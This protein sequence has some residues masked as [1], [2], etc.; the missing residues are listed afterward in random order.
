LGIRFAEQHG[1]DQDLSI[2]SSVKSS[3]DEQWEQ[4]WGELRLVRDHHN[5]LRLNVIRK[6]PELNFNL[7]IKAC[8]VTTDALVL[9]TY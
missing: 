5:Q 7:V 4:P 6:K 8:R 1:L 9:N 2:Q 3:Q